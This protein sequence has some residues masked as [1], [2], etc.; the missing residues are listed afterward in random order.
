MSK[1]L[2][3]SACRNSNYTLSSVALPVAEDLKQRRFKTTLNS[4]ILMKKMR[5]FSKELTFVKTNVI[6]NT[7]LILVES[8]QED[9][10]L[11][12]VPKE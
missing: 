2:L 12:T 1:K 9:F 10:A 3:F 4:S 7:F 11:E 8:F 6:N 5:G